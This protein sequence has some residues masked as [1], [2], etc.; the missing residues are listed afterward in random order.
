MSAIGPII[1]WRMIRYSPE[2]RARKARPY[3][4]LVRKPQV[5]NITGDSSWYRRRHLCCAEAYFPEV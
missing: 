2:A 1:A 5:W 4:R 3:D